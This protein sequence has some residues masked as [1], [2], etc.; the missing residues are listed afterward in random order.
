MSDTEPIQFP[1]QRVGQK[2]K[3]QSLSHLALEPRSVVAFNRQELNAIMDVYG[4]KVAAGEWR[5]YALDMMKDKAIFSVFRHASE[6]PLYRIEKNP[7]LSRK[8]G[9]Y[10]IQ[11]A[12]GFILKRGNEL[13]RVLEILDRSLRLIN[14]Q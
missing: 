5:D 14:A 12:A 11:N 2:T 1:I 3:A 9:A 7:K 10:S 4:K 8:Q 6:C 13:K